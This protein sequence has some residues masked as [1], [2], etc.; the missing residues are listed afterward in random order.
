MKVAIAGSKGLLGSAITS[1][2]SSSGDFDLIE[3][4]REKVDLSN[5]SEVLSTLRLA[6]PEKLVLTAAK[7]GGISANIDFPV[8]FI[9]Q[10]LMI[11]TAVMRAAHDTDIGELVFMGSSCIY[12]PSAPIPLGEESLLSG[13][14]HD[15]NKGY[16]LAKLVGIQLVESYNRQHGRNW[17]VLLPSNLYGNE[18]PSNLKE[19]HVIPA[20]VNKFLQAKSF[21]KPEVDVWGTGTALREFTHARDIAKGVQM[22]LEDP[23][24]P[25]IMNIGSGE[26]VSIQSLATIIADACGY[27]G[28][29]NF[30]TEA[31][32]GVKRKLLDS[33]EIRKMGWS[34]EVTLRHGIEE[35]V[36][37]L[38]KF[39][40]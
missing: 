1:R 12:P 15:S 2:L 30:D 23:P 38:K 33:S 10:N 6:K 18:M 31:P 39:G 16:A 25:W 34:P 13:S 32:E 37:F 17:K 4:S 7:V 8:D 27:Q 29:I 14:L 5:Y 9:E 19:G 35:Y 40:S 11:Q 22:L 36:E 28:R 26:E 3:L 21:G 24:P 20:L